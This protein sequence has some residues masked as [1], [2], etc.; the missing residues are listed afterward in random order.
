MCVRYPPS[1]N[2]GHF[3]KVGD[4]DLL[5]D[6]EQVR[7]SLSVSYKSPPLKSTPFCMNP[8]CI[9]SFVFFFFWK[10]HKLRSKEVY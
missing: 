3:G 9:F 10:D 5:S 2:P 1:R 4:G 8:K 7:Q 6:T